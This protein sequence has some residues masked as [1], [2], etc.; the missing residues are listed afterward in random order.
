MIE[1]EERENMTMRDHLDMMIETE[2]IQET[3]GVREID[4]GRLEGDES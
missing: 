1:K 3:Q 2:E 4:L